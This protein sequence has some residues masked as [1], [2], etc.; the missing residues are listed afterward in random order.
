MYRERERERVFGGLGKRS[1]PFGGMLFLF[2]FFN[3]LFHTIDE[4]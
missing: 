2:Y 3:S 1:D 4:M